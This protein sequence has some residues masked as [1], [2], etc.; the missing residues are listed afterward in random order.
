MKKIL[1][2]SLLFLS[3]I[4]GAQAQTCGTTITNFP[5]FQNFEA[6]AGGWTS[7]G[8]NTSWALGTPAKSVINSAA[9]GTKSWV[10]NL[11]GQYN[12]S[13]QSFVESPC[14]NT[15]SLVN[16]V[17]EMKIWWNSEFSYD[18]AVLQ[19]S[20]DG[21]MS[22]QNVGAMGDPNNWYNDNSINGVPGGQA[23]GSAQGW[24]GRVSSNNGSGG[25]VVARHALTGLGG[26][27]SVKLRIA[28][29]SDGIIADEGFSFDDVAVFE[30][31]ANDAAVT[32]ISS[33]S[34]SVQPNVSTPITVTLKNTGTAN[35]TAATMGFSVNGAVVSNNFAF[36]GNLAP[37]Q[38]SSVTISNHPFPAGIHTLKT[39]S[40]LPN[41]ASDGNPGNDTATVRIY[42]CA[43]LAGTYTINKN[44][45]ASA[46][47]FQSFTAAAQLLNNCGVSGPV[48]FNV[49]GGPYTETVVLGNVAGASTANTITFN[50]NGNALVN[51]SAGADALLLSGS[52]YFR[53]NNLRIKAAPAATGGAVVSLANAAQQNIFTGCSFTHSIS[54][55]ATSQAVNLIG[56]SSNNS[57]QG[58]TLVGAYHGVFNNGTAATPN[59]GNQFVGNVIRDPYFYGLYNTYAAN[60]LIQ[61]TDISRVTRT[62]GSSMYGIYFSTGVTGAT[63]SKNRIHNTHDAATVTNG[64]VYGIFNASTGAAG[65]ENIFLNNAIWN[66]NNNTGTFYGIYTSGSNAWFYYNTVSADNSANTYGTLRG[67]YVAAAVSNVKFLNNNISLSSPATSK[68]AL[69]IGSATASLISNNNNLYPGTNGNVGYFTTDQATLAAWKTVNNNAYDLASISADPIFVSAATGNLR[70]TNSS[71]DGVAQPLAAVTDDI[72]GAARNTTTP[73]IGAWEFAPAANDA[74]IVT[75]IS[76]TS[77][78]IP[79]AI[80]PVSVTLK[81]FGISPLTSVTINWTINSVAQPAFAWTGNLATNQTVNVPIGNYTF[82]AGNYTLTACTSNPNGA[83]DPNTG[84]DCQTVA[85][86]A[87]N[88]LAG[89]Y[90][91]NK[92][93]A[94]SATNYTTFTSLVSTLG[95]CGISA[96]VTINVVSGTGPYNEN[97]TIGFINGTSATNTITLNGNGNILR[98]QSTTAEA[99]L[100]LN[101]ARYFRFNNLGMEVAAGTTGGTVLTLA[102]SAQNNTFDGCT[103]T[104]S[105]TT[106][107]VSQGVYVLT[108]SSDNIVRNS[109]ITGAYYGVY[110]NGTTTIPNNN[111]KF[112]GN[113]VKDPHFYGFSNFYATGTLMEGN[114]ISRPTR[115]NAGLFYGIYNGTN[116]TGVVISK[117]RIH[118]TQD[119]ATTLAVSVYGIYTTAVGTVGAENIIR[120]NAIYQINNAGG[121]LYG[122]YNSNAS[123]TYY[124][125]NTVSADIPTATYNTIGGMYFSAASTNVKFI[126]NIIS[127]SSTA[128]TKNAIYLAASG[129]S[130]VSNNNNFHAP[131]GMVGFWGSAM[132]TLNDWKSANSGVYDQNSVSADPF[133]VNAAAGDLRPT[134]V[135]LNN[136]GQA[137]ASVTDD[138]TGAPRSAT[139]PDMGAF[140]FTVNPNDVGIV[141]IAGPNVTGCGLSAAET[142]TVTIKNFGT[143]TQT[144]IPVSYTLSGNTVNETFTGSIP[145]NTTATYA[146]TAKANLGTP[147]T[148]QLTTTTVLTGDSNAGNNPDTLNIT[149]SLIPTLP[150]AFDFE[151]ANTGISRFRK[152]T[153]TSSAITEDAGASIG[154]GSVKGLILDGMNNANW[155]TPVGVTDP[156]TSNP[157]NFAAA[158][159]CI[160]PAGGLAT[161]SLWLTFDLKQLFKTAN[162]NTNFR[163]TVNGTQVGPTFRPPFSGTPITWQ[164]VKVDLFAY[165]NDPSVMIGL[166]SSV[167]EAFANGAGTA[168]LLDNVSV[169]RRLVVSSPTGVK[170]NDLAKQLHVFPN[171][172]KGSF[173]VSLKNGMDYNLK[174]TDLTG[175]VI[176]TQKA[177]GETRLNLEGTA[178]GIYLLNVTSVNGAVVR[179][180]IVE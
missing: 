103:F 154:T 63:V 82:A 27:S 86:V 78:V 67:F 31:P 57:F 56:G 75:I 91:I 73:D 69:Y 46:T 39:W 156:W 68:H 102:N 114:D 32:F 167:R 40:R 60:T 111:N 9:S 4:G 140:E 118:N 14:F 20:I 175:K 95:S 58:D 33:P 81:N 129:I 132:A 119:A 84:A 16:P 120:N 65:A 151:T 109:T 147:G 138:I 85:L 93:L 116:A 21:G 48:I 113:M 171:P 166:E 8:T 153:N 148:Y 160:S 143:T 24:T 161:D 98:S 144:S 176:L 54:I 169:L 49:A 164:K 158:Y 50:G 150:F 62:N 121:I 180:L 130:L 172:S 66:I 38:T 162:A 90:T 1:P 123:N 134:V 72:T 53:F 124:Y 127:L 155:L 92:N 179:K 104:H 122:L 117:N 173:F 26:K 37:N 170:E 7:G 146:F 152:V 126:N 141:A 87:C 133:F 43:S 142:I 11:A 10:T 101:A 168:N 70:P 47:N 3:A 13:E 165:K 108:G 23:A 149:N 2:L 94:A 97:V 6:G 51:A 139:T 174:V 131:G 77:P 76:P 178:K 45:Q 115:T 28:F 110:V 135:V 112:I 64:T 55:T 5:Y 99:V 89:T 145:T 19:S 30:L 157:D 52:K 35:L 136:V 105:T 88:P 107:S 17:I 12:L 163:V 36:S 25:W 125:N 61:G 22:W 29:G 42:S 71:L 137:L 177:K 159:I 79:N 59:N 44:L 96:P 41:G 34:G 18:G 74:G 15:T 83:V 100:K 80:Q 106:T 128:G